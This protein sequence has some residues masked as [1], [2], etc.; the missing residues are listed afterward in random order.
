[1]LP[2]QA[3]GKRRWLAW[4][5]PI[6]PLVLLLEPSHGFAA[7]LVFSGSLER[8]GHE[9]ISIRLAD[10]RIIDARLSSA[11]A[12]AAGRLTAGKLA[13]QYNIGDQVQITCKPIQA[14]WEDETSQYQSLEL[15]KLRFVRLATSGELAGRFELPPWREGVNLLSRRPAP[16]GS[17]SENSSPAAKNGDPVDVVAHRKLEHARDVNLEYASSMPN[18]VA[19]ETAKRY[20]SNSASPKWRYLDTIETEI[21]FKGSHAVRQ[22]IRRDSKPWDKPF[23]ALPGFKWYG[24]FGT[25]IRPLFDLQC[26]TT[27]DYE[28]RA[29]VRGKHLLKYRYSSPPDGCFGPFFVDYQRYNPARTGH[30]FIDDP[31]GNIIKLEEDATGFPD[32]F[33]F[34]QRKEEVTWDNVKIGDASHLMPVAAN[35]MVLY[36]AGSRW[37]VEVEYRNHRHFETSTNITFH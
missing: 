33:E 35:F 36:A 23:Q 25:E 9:S 1:M 2:P 37:R 27:I 5:A 8:V 22:Q 26:P 13:A 4:L 21:T 32:E 11:S 3:R 12:S 18:F 15:I 7:D 24:G 28:G 29:E 10:R 19:D 17:E 34:A 20:T 14:V 31:E 16:A 30:I 6:A